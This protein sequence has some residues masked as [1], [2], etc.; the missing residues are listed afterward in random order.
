MFRDSTTRS[1]GEVAA[2][3]AAAA[4]PQGRPVK[5]RINGVSRK[6][7]DAF[8]LR[9]SDL[10][11]EQGEFVTL[12]G[13]SGSGKTTLLMMIAGLVHPTSGEIWIDGRKATRQ[14]PYERDVG[15]MFQSYALFPHMTVGENIAFPLKMRRASDAAIR[16]A[17]E[18]V[19]E[20]IKLPHIRNRFPS[21]LSGGQQQRV[22]LARSIVHRPSVVLMDEP[23]AALDKSLRAHMQLEIR[24]LQQQLGITVLYVTHDQEEAMTMS[25]RIC[26]MNEARIEQVATPAELYFSPRTVFAAGFVGESNSFDGEI[27]STDG[28]QALVRTPFGQ[29]TGRLM[30]AGSKGARCKVM[31]RPEAVSC[32]S[33]D[34]SGQNMIA[35]EVL[36]H[37]I[38]GAIAR[39]YVRTRDGQACVA[40]DLTRRTGDAPS[41]QVVMSFRIEDT[42]VYGDGS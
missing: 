37:V 5:L 22:A 13:P 26:L 6:Y 24:Q 19:L 11:I 7:G 27:V 28:A 31:V 23:L 4:L 16:T 20:Q 41:G 36:S 30:G 33:V 1:A 3:Q 9:P 42:L 32:S 15:M 39:T 14:Q 17:V 25:D 29:I 8:A 35:G 38:A 12:L 18:D 34:A 2:D 10:D 40:T 21:E